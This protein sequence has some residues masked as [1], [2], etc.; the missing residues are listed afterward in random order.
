M[1]YVTYADPKFYHTEET[2]P[3]GQVLWR[4]HTNCFA[5]LHRF[6]AAGR[7]LGTDVERVEGTRDSG[8]RDWA[9]LEEMIVGLGEMEF[10][11][12]RVKPFRVEVGKVVHGLIYE[13]EQWEK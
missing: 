9:K 10:R 6:D 2:T 12:I 1:G 13:P 3:D 4:E 11:D 5:V 7:H 8:P